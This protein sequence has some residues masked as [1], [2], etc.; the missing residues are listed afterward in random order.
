MD[1]KRKSLQMNQP[2]VQ[3]M[4]QGS[5]W[6]EPLTDPSTPIKFGSTEGKNGQIKS[7]SVENISKEPGETHA[8]VEFYD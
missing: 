7:K 4:P 6:D 1:E 3:P 5:G 8:S 2:G